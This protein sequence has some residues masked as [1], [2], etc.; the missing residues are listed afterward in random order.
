[1]LGLMCFEFVFKIVYCSAL[2]LPLSLEW[3]PC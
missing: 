1:M 3:R 2:T